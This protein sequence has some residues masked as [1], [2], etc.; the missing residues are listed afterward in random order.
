MLPISTEVINRI[1]EIAIKEGQPVI[2]GNF[3]FHN[4]KD[5]LDDIIDSD[6]G[7]N[8]YNIDNESENKI[9]ET[10]LTTYNN[11]DSELYKSDDVYTV[12]NID[13]YDDDSVK[14]VKSKMEYYNNIE[15]NENIPETDEKNETDLDIFDENDDNIKK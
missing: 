3:E 10:R 2:K 1:H 5:H 6:N 15:D 4:V 13:T 7:S 9:D 14:L 12:H 8:N 11:T